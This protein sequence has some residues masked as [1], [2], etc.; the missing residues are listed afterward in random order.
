MFKK[1]TSIVF[2]LLLVALFA[3]NVAQADVD[4]DKVR[5][6]LPKL[7]GANNAGTEFV[8]GFHPCWEEFGANNALR[9]YV[10]S[11]VVTQVSLTIPYFS[12]EPYLIKTTKPND[13]IEFVLAP[14]VG[15]PYTRGSG[16]QVSTLKPTQVWQGRGIILKADAP[17]IAYGVTRYQYTSDGF[18]AV[19]THALSKTYII[20]SYRETANFQSQSLT[21]YADII[22]VFDKT[23][24][25]FHIG[26]NNATTVRTIDDKKWRPYDVLRADLN[27]GDFWLIASEGPQSDIGGSYVTA[28][29][30]IAVL[31]GSHCA[32]IPTTVSA[33]DFIIEQELPVIAWGKKYHITNIVDR[34]K[35][36]VIR[37]F[38]K[39]P[40]TSFIR[41]GGNEIGY[42]VTNFGIEGEGWLETRHDPDTNKPAV[43]TSNKAINVVQYNQGM[44]DDNVPSDPFQLMLTPEEQFQNE[45]IFNTPGIRGGYGFRRNYINIVYKSDSSGQIPDDLMLGEVFPTGETKWTKIR[46]LS[47]APGAIFQDPDQFDKKEKYYSK[48][49]PMPYDAVYRLKVESQK[50]AAYAYGFADWDSYGFPTSIALADLEKPD[51]VCPIPVYQI[52]CDG[53]TFNPK[54][55]KNT[56]IVMDMPDN[57][58][59]RTN[60]AIVIFHRNES[61]NY[62]FEY[63]DFIPGETRTIKWSLRT[64]DPGQDARALITFAD[65]AGNDTTIKI[66]YNAIK[67]SIT[68]RTFYYGNMKIGDSKTQNFVVKNDSKTSAAVL[69]ELSLQSFKYSL[70][71]QGFK[72][73]IPDDFL[74]E[75]LPPG[76]T[77]SFS[78]TFTATKE[79]EFRDSIGVGDTCFYQFKSLIR[80]SVGTP[81]INVTD[82]D[83]KQ[84]TVGFKTNPMI[85]TITNTG[86]TSLEITGYI[87]NKLSV[88]THDLPEITKDN[89]L[90]IDKG[91]SYQFN[92]WFEP[93]A[94]K[95][96]EDEIVFISDAGTNIDNVCEIIGEGIEP[97]LEAT[98]D[99]W[100]RK[101]VHLTRYDDPTSIYKFT[102]YPSPNGAIELRNEGSKD[103]SISKINIV[104][105]TLGDA[106]EIMVNGNLEPITKYVNSLGQIR[107]KDGKSITVIEK[108]GYRQIP[109]YFHPKTEGEHKLVLEYE[110][111]APVKP[112]SVLEG[113]GIYP[114]ISTIDLDFGTKVIGDAP[115]KQTL[116]FINE[117]WDYSDQVEIAQLVNVPNGTISAKIGTYGTEGFNY[118][119]DAIRLDMAGIATFPVKLNPGQFIELDCEFA[120]SK[121]GNAQAVLTTLSDAAAEAS[122]NWKG[123]GI[124]EGLEM[125]EGNEPY[126]CYN[127]TDE[128]KVLLRNTGSSAVNVLPGA[129]TIINDASN[130]FVIDRVT[131]EDLSQVNYA[132]G[133]PL[134]SGETVNIFVKYIPKTWKQVNIQELHEAKVQVKTDAVTPSLQTLTADVKGRAIHFTRTSESKINGLSQVTVD[135]GQDPKSKPITYSIYIN[136]GT[137][138]DVANPTEFTI[139]MKYIKNF[140]AIREEN[141]KLL[142]NVGADMPAGWTVKSTKLSLDKATNEETV[143]IVLT[144]M[145]PL[146]KVERTELVKV[147]FI[148]WLPWYTNDQGQVQ[149]K[150]KTIDITHTIATNEQCVDYINPVGSKASLTEVCVDNLR[151]IVIS[152]ADYNLG[153]INPN[154]VTANGTDLPFS[155]AFDGF[156]EIRIVNAA[157][158]IVDIPVSG[159]MKA[160]AYSIRLPI[161]KLSNGAYI[162]EM[163]SGEFR[164]TRKFNVVK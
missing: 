5:A 160:G 95:V 138:L 76:Q 70:E 134:A 3:N 157:G 52:F 48:I 125:V 126:I 41:N 19:P 38:A 66:D 90:I 123:F 71:S 88:Y 29:K 155:I 6:T 11:P 84:R 131:R 130:V 147:E 124:A 103:V 16:G 61:F 121:T 58:T 96:F 47:G 32:Y 53:S 31:S 49:I 102:P 23:R 98:G 113:I 101:R 56:G 99:N 114:K 109:V 118:N 2:S 78:A 141:N 161:E 36:S 85:A 97:M 108:N 80:A 60:L 164:E 18:L 110:S 37:M 8:F 116:R 142:I 152:A 143:V 128:I 1:F 111:D 73:N 62:L 92:V 30:P 39:E 74:T 43:I 100:G 45:I 50:I 63:D 117:Q 24:V 15:Q 86:T 26:G 115:A 145:T 132:N 119:G 153:A 135:P 79:G 144:G 10:S 28:N 146:K 136:Q 17:I 139:T 154:P 57:D 159:D 55:G 120:P 21:P 54:N 81:I 14:A 94:V 133:F 40:N 42:L 89:P 122:S 156:V 129:V 65:R 82:V 68:P 148:S 51:T 127:T 34:K 137:L 149:V 20:S 27:R 150:S 35:A 158:N 107:D 22:G 7:L 9:I 163:V 105:N 77:R 25:T 69:T 4:I 112:T 93:D 83:F 44:S 104:E 162:L 67:L 59:I 140:L 87:N 75:P 72:L 12:Q 106:F 33:C 151:P 13:I 91:G 46:D 64:I